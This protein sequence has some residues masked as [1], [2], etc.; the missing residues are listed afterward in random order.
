MREA[1]RILRQELVLCT[2]L[3][4]LQEELADC[5]KGH[6][7]GNGV[8]KTVRE[9]ECVLA[10]IS[11]LEGEQKALLER[12]GKPDLRSFL[13]GQ[14]PSVEREM[15]LRLLDQVSSQQE[16]LRKQS[17]ANR[18]LLERSK[19]FVDFQMNVLSRTKANPTY[20][21][22]NAGEAEHQ[23]GRRMFDQNV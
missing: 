22:P 5:L 14:S 12:A 17:A 9:L 23:R 3:A 10:D 18:L 19:Q 20:G 21:P 4:E 1:I 7:S 13:D 16:K 8:S 6:V 11:K 15:A 2:R